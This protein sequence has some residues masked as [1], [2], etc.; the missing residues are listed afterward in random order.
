MTERGASSLVRHE[1]SI[2]VGASS[3]ARRDGG[4]ELAFDEICAPIPR[5]VRGRARIDLPRLHEVE[6][7]LD[8][9]GAHFWR[10][11]APRAR[12]AVELDAPKLSWSGE[13]YVDSNY[14][15]RPLETDFASWNWSRA[16]LQSGA[17]IVY[18]ALRRDGE[19]T[20]I[21]LKY[22]DDDEPVPFK[23][24]SLV[25]L[26]PTLWRLRGATRADSGCTPRLVRRLEDAPFYSRSVLGLAL[27]GEDVT[28]VHESLSLDRFCAPTTQ[29][30]L[31]FRMPRRG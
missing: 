31:P 24:P 20:L 3:L 26:P 30:M 22:C 2:A 12:I 18:E 1:S 27:L 5:R 17:A 16:H 23:P 14:G 28:A 9:Q 19:T 4:L 21:A 13:C 6:Y 15:A 25:A 10:P 11:L 8:H 29:F 7:A